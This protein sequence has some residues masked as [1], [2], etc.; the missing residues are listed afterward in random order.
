MTLPILI[1]VMCIPSLMALFVP[2]LMVRQGNREP[3]KVCL[4]CVVLIGLALA[5]GITGRA[6]EP[7]ISMA[8]V[9][10][11]AAAAVFALSL[12]LPLWLIKPR[13]G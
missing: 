7:A 2:W 8:F 12:A 1:A 11:T 9:V 10:C 4:F 6:G 13:K 5:T 3:V